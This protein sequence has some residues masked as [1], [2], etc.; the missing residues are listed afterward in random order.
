MFWSKKKS[1]KIHPDLV[2][3]IRWQYDYYRSMKNVNSLYITF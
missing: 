1:K 3:I 2:K